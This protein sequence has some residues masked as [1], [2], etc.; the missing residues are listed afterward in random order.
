MSNDRYSTPEA[1][2][3][4]WHIPL[5]ENFKR[6]DRDVEIRDVKANRSNYA[7]ES[8]ALYRATDTGDVFYA[9]GSNWTPL[10]PP[11]E[12]QGGMTVNG[13][14]SAGTYGLSSSASPSENADALRTAIKSND[15]V[16]IPAGTY[17]CDRVQTWG[18]GNTTIYGRGTLKA[19]PNVD[20]WEY[21]LRFRG[22]G[23]LVVDG[24]T[25]DGD[26]ND[27]TGRSAV[28]FEDATAVTMKNCEVKNWQDHDGR[29]DQPHAVNFVGCRGVWAV[30]NHVHHVGAKGINAY[31][32]NSDPV[33]SVVFRGNYV[34]DIGEEALFCGSEE[35]DSSNPARFVITGNHLADNRSQYLVR[36][37]GNGGENNTIIANNAAENAATAGFN[38]KT[39]DVTA[40]SVTIANNVYRGGGRAGISVQ[41]TGNGHLAA[42][43]TGNRVVDH[44]GR[45]ILFESECKNVLCY[46]N[47]SNGIQT[48]QTDA[49]LVFGNMTYGYG[50]DL[51]GRNIKSQLNLSL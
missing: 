23:H 27:D 40:S 21:L 25:L 3:L 18:T 12:S 7:P 11:D 1:G 43:V 14:A 17:V 8:G 41:S 37:A 49:A 5:N 46:G 29:T 34:H 2:S 19:S 22:G 6:L 13:H 39:P 30:D 42:T 44:S 4:D 9:D 47:Y 32:R 16:Y 45:G 33:D 24:L 48:Q 36:I 50:L 20:R 28:R 26:K 31:A 51:E 15:V 35:N 38:Y 10:N